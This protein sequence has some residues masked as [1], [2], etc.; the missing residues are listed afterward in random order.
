M[1][2]YQVG[3]G[4]NYLSLRWCHYHLTPLWEEKRTWNKGWRPHCQLAHGLWLSL[5]GSSANSKW[6]WKGSAWYLLKFPLTSYNVLC[7]FQQ[8][9]GDGEYIRRAINQNLMKSTLMW[10]EEGK[11]EGMEGL[12]ETKKETKWICNMTTLS[13]WG[14]YV[15]FWGTVVCLSGAV[16]RDYLI[17]DHQQTGHP[18]ICV[19]KGKPTTSRHM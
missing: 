4:G 15:I 19:Q 16:S 7:W 5:Y 14:K 1:T 3:D 8:I 9:Y 10:R 6:M 11:E 17:A 12:R 18:G 13:E 2:A